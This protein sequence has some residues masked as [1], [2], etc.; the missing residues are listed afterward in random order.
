MRKIKMSKELFDFLKSNKVEGRCFKFW[1]ENFKTE[2][3]ILKRNWFP[4]FYF[5]DNADCMR[6]LN[7]PQVAITQFIGLKDKNGKEI[8]EGDIVRKWLGCYTIDLK[9][10]KES[11]DEEGIFEIKFNEL[12]CCFGLFYDDGFCGGLIASEYNDKGKRHIDWRCDDV[13]VI[14]NIY[15]LFINN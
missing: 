8:Y 4:F 14:G 6:N 12:H 1:P 15:Q 5:Y 3:E 13:E 10:G 7:D 11:Q 2:F 9:T